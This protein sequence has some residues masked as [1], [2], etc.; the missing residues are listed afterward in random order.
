MLIDFSFSGASIKIQISIVL[1]IEIVLKSF[2][3]E[4]N[5][6]SLQQSNS[7]TNLHQIILFFLY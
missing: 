2:C 5:I 4:N 3:K 7:F 6:G 1:K